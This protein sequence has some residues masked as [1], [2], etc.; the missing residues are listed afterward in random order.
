VIGKPIWY[1]AAKFVVISFL[2]RAESS[3]SPV[4]TLEIVGT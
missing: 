1:E 2:G 4:A 3:P